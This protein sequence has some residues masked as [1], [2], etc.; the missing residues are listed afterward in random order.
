MIT[1]NINLINVY[2]GA[3]SVTNKYNMCV[4]WNFE[5]ALGTSFWPLYTYFAH[6]CLWGPPCCTRAQTIAVARSNSWA[7]RKDLKYT[8]INYNHTYVSG[9]THIRMCERAHECLM[10]L[11]KVFFTTK[12][13]CFLEFWTSAKNSDVL[14]LARAHSPRAS[15]NKRRVCF[16]ILDFHYKHM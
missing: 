11:H 10:L 9:I 6:M 2:R 4:E 13:E 1:R 14:E 7:Y 15:W 3:D 12:I 5:Q 8:N 16:V